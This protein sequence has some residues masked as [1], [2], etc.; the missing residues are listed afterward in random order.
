M[1]ED[2]HSWLQASYLCHQKDAD[3]ATIQ[4]EEEDIFIKNFFTLDFDGCWLGGLISAESGEWISPN[5]T[6][7]GYFPD[8]ISN[9]PQYDIGTCLY[10]GGY[11]VIGFR[12]GRCSRKYWALCSKMIQSN[13]TQ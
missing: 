8:P 5:G 10:M 3:L 9:G 13:P 7:F 1:I 2:S 6:A 12:V 4:S 11:N